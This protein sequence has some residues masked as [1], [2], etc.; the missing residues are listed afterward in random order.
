VI[1]TK[2]D[3]ELDAGMA[4]PYRLFFRIF[5]APSKHVL[6]DRNACKFDGGFM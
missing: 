5:T 2:F 4:A 3:S 6:F 1:L